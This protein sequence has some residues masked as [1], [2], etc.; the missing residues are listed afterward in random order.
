M[1]TKK[2]ATRSCEE[3]RHLERDMYSMIEFLREKRSRR[4]RHVQNRDKDEA[5]IKIL[6]IMTADGKRK[7]GAP[8][9][10][11]IESLHTRL[12]PNAGRRI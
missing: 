5:A 7:R 6:Y 4:F 2:D 3:C 12:S 11:L 1:G 10:L 8:K 9:L